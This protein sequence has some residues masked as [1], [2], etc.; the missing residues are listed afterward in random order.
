MDDPE[1]M[2]EP[3]MATSEVKMEEFLPERACTEGSENVDSLIDLLKLFK[4]IYAL[5]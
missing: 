3:D 4:A 1:T 2:D 5:N